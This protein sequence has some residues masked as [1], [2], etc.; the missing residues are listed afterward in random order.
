MLRWEEEEEGPRGGEEGAGS[1]LVVGMGGEEEA[2]ACAHVR[3]V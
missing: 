1:G 3:G 2:P